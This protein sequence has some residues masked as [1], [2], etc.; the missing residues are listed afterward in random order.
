MKDLKTTMMERDNLTAS[1][2]DEM[3][4]D[5]RARILTGEDPEE[6]LLEDFGLEPDYLF[7]IL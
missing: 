5:A 4:A 2:V 1:E 6:I 7:D 3:I